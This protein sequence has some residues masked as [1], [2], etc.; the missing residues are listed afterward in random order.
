MRHF[1]C[2][3]SIL[4]ILSF[5]SV[6]VV[7]SQEKS[8]I[9]QEKDVNIVLITIDTLRADH[10]SCYGYERETTPHIDKIAA[11]GF[12]F[13]DVIAPSSW[14]SPSMVSLFTS[15][16]PINHGI[17]K[18]FIQEKKIVNQ[19]VFS[20]DLITLAEILQSGGYTTFGVASN[21][22]LCEDYGFARGF[23]YFKCLSFHPAPSVNKTVYSWEKEIREADKFFLWL[24]YF[25]PHHYYSARSPWIEQYASESLTHELKL[26]KKSKEELFSLIPMLKEEDEAHSNLV[27]LYDSEVNYVDY[28]VAEIIQKF[29]FDED[30]LLIITSDHGEE[31]LEHGLLGHANNL[32][33]E[34]IDIPLIIRLPRQEIGK[35]VTQQAS[36]LDIMPTIL[37]LLEIP[38]SEQMLGESLLTKKGQER[39]LPDR[40]LFSELQKGN[41]NMKA[42]LTDEWK[43]IHNHKGTIEKLYDWAKNILKEDW[44]HLFNYEDPVVGLYNRKQDPHEKENLIKENPSVSA[45]LKEQLLQWVNTSHSYPATKITVSLYRELQEKLKALG[46]ISEKN[47]SP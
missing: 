23:N 40:I 26:Y 38:L 39:K 18:G 11:K 36:L 24:H 17:I 37:T 44:R 46:Y 9:T 2:F 12:V 25:D 42:I 33:G 47:S 41:H 1:L 8:R 22:H 15:V 10:L 43:Y 7:F 27:A 5:C 35:T 29:G 3:L 6:G 16:Y 31:F 21:L 20:D 32:Y 30:T 28:H 34:T 14:T 4:A 13:K 45:A 19:E